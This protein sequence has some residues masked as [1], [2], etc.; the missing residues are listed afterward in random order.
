MKSPRISIVLPCRNEVAFVDRCLASVF[1][2]E[3][4]EGGFEVL[5]V[6]GL[7]QDGTRGKIAAWQETHPEIRM[8]DNPRGIV[9]TAMN[10][11]IGAARG[12]L[13]LRLDMHAT[14]PGNYLRLCVEANRRTS[15][16]NVGGVMMTLPRG[17]SRSAVVVQAMTTHRFGVGNAEFRLGAPEGPAD[18]VPY[19]CFPMSIFARVGLYDERLVR[20]Q[21]YEMNCRIRR[22]GG[23]VWMNPEIKVFYYNQSTLRGLIQQAITTSMWNTWMWYVAPYAFAYRHMIPG[24]FVAAVLCCL[25]LTSFV[26]W[27][28]YL[29]GAILL[30]YALLAFGASTQQAKRKGWW[31]LPVLPVCFLAYH[32]AYGAGILWGALHLMLHAAP[33]QHQ[34]EPWPG[35]GRNTPLPI[36]RHETTL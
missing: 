6:D 14:Y 32:L 10:I 25:L 28:S 7:S 18:T 36:I 33:V 22:L 16:D 27:G 2:F 21:D 12:E 20:N 26:P 11:G 19:G 29:L 8:L 24:I 1:E 23:V 30:P 4:V 5:I 35:A 31:L 34:R 3:Q 9:P 15:A 13:L 17:S